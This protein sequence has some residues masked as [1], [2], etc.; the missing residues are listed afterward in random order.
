MT[1]FW[2][3][4]ILLGRMATAHLCALYLEGSGYKRSEVE[5]VVLRGC[6]A[7]KRR[8]TADDVP[9]LQLLRL[10]ARE[11]RISLARGRPLYSKYTLGDAAAAA[12]AAAA[13]AA[14][15]AKRPLFVWHVSARR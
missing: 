5:M 15:P 11:Y 2:G 12:A 13:P 3:G 4:S 14:V 1:F 7:I 10:C 9:K 6:N 8:M